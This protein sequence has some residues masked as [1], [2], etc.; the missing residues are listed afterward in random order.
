MSILHPF[1][2]T[3]HKP[4][5]N[6][7]LQ[8]SGPM[9]FAMIGNAKVQPEGIGEKYSNLTLAGPTWMSQKSLAN[10]YPPGNCHI[11]QK[12]HFEDDFPFPQ[13]GYVNYLEGSKWVT[14][15]I[16]PIYK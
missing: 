16:C 5:R 7:G 12:W 6:Q 11:P 10:G 13:M 8:K 4:R 1:G 15:S 14:I 9:G 2:A 3:S